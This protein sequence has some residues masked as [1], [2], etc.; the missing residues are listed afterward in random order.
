MKHLAVT[1]PAWGQL[2][3]EWCWAVCAT[4]AGKG[5]ADPKGPPL[6]ASVRAS[7]SA[8]TLCRGPVCS[9][10]T[11]SHLVHTLTFSLHHDSY[12]QKRRTFLTLHRVG[13]FSMLAY[14][15]HLA[16]QLWNPSLPLWFFAGP[17]MHVLHRTVRDFLP[18]PQHCI[19]IL[20]F[21]VK[22]YSYFYLCVP[23]T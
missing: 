12:A 17:R 16:L 20:V 11:F 15:G 4:V 23:G 18:C 2:C 21:M 13:Q 8:G 5:G 10:C 14:P 9:W 1:T 22:G 3:W 19:T 6:A 7:L